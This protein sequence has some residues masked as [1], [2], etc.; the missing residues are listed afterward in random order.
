MRQNNQQKPLARWIAASLAA[1][2]MAGFGAQAVA[3]TAAG[4]IIKNLATVT[5]ED[6]NGNKYSAQSN[7]AFVTVAEV[8]DASIE[9][10]KS[11]SAAPGQTVYFPHT[12]TNNGNATDTYKINTDTSVAG[13]KVYNDLNNNGQPDPGEPEVAADGTITLAAGEQANLV[14]A[15]PIPV[16]AESGDILTADLLATSEN[17]D[18]VDT[19]TPGDAT[20]TVVDT[21]TVTT[22]P[23]LVLG[24]QSVHDAVNNTITY[25][26]TVKNNGGSDATNVNILDAVPEANGFDD[27]GNPVVARL[28]LVSVSTNGL[29]NSGD[30]AG[31]LNANY[32]ESDTDVNLNSS[33]TDTGLEV[34]EAT[35]V[36]LPPNTTVSVTYVVSYDSL[37]EAGQTWD[38]WLAG[39]RIENTFVASYT[40]P[41]DPTNVLSVSS[42]ETSDVL[43]QYY[44]VD[45]EDDGQGT[46]TPSTGPDANNGEDDGTAT[47][48]EQY[49]ASVPTGAEVLF[50]HVITNEG[51]G[52]DVFNLGVTNTD[53][54]DGTIFT[55]W[56]STN[57]VQVTDTD[58]D[59]VPDTGTL[60]FGEKETI[61]IRAKL[62][63]GKDDTTE[64]PADGYNAVLTATSA[65]AGNDAD[66]TDDNDST[67]LKLGAI[68]AA[69]VDIVTA[70]VPSAT[71]AGSQGYADTDGFNVNGSANA[72]EN[73]PVVLVDSVVGGSV[74]FDLQLANES[75]T[76]DSYLLSA[77]NVP[78]GWNVVFKDKATGAVITT[79]PLLVGLGDPYEYQ[80]VVTISADP[81]LAK[82]DSDQTG[83]VDGYKNGLGILTDGDSDD[84]Y[85]I[86]FIASSTGTVGLKDTVR[87]AIDVA[88]MREVV[89]TPNGQNQIQ[90]GGTVDYSHLLE[91]N[92]NQPEKVELDLSNTLAGSGWTTI[93]NIDHDGDD[94]TP[95][96]PLNTLVGQT[97][98]GIVVTDTDGDNNYELLL[99]AGVD[100]AMS[101]TVNAPSNA[102]QGAV[103]LS[104]ITVKD[105]NDEST[106]MDSAEDQTNVILGQVRL[107]KKAA[108][109]VDC[110]GGE[111]QSA[112][113]TNQTTKVE[114]GQCVT[115]QLIATNEGN[116][117][118]KNVVMSDAAPAFTDMQAT[119]SGG[120]TAL[121]F[122][123]VNGCDPTPVTDSTNA[124]ITGNI[125]TFTPTDGELKSGET[126]T[127]QFTVKVQ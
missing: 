16:T 109:D 7:E 33:L 10:N 83:A 35:D 39:D 3:A 1:G 123:E 18:V 49:V 118:V 110:D 69:A 14:V 84:D 70:Y 85:Y 37:V 90:P 28:E 74:T 38:T 23:V 24:K 51:N 34:I 117:T 11:L 86:D 91:N 20:G 40:D 9:A 95:M 48:D 99:P 120:G 89:I 12:L 53:F 108:I 21:A 52:D 126:A 32:N 87:N 61:V 103:D 116:A 104:T 36:T 67:N 112:F 79:T 72:Q 98:N 73:G 96:V 50:T 88:P 75:G 42:N 121:E 82:S 92:G 81:A 106:I 66:A 30:A 114:P 105:S 41:S 59:G 47:D 62:P 57:T 125:V 107:E 5:Y 64:S 56:D 44:A 101:T 13:V 71:V 65:N 27:A 25:T 76:S 80:A 124:V 100:L 63:A 55:F 26:L 15:M 68:S 19:T 43:P 46:G 8:F 45:A 4:T 60:G 115:W 97:V 113:S 29:V 6:A 58:N 17:G 54:P 119:Y 2:A 78:A 111:P 122:C 94:T 77:D 93:I 127:G 31:A 22:D 102:P